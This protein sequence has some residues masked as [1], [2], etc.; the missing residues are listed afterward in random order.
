MFSPYKVGKVSVNP[1]LVLAPMS[2]VTTSAF[3]RLVKELNPGAVGLVMTEFISV[4]ALSRKVQRSIDMMHYDV[5]EHPLAIQ[6]FGYDIERL[7]ESARMAE[8][9]GAD[10]VDIN[11]GCPAP[12]VVKK[13]GG[14]EL[15]RQPDHL[16]KMIAAARKAIS[17]PLTIKIRSGWDEQSKNALE[18]ATMAEQEGVDA[19]A[20]HGRTRAQLYRGEADWDLVADVASKLSIP[21]LGSGDVTSRASADARLR[22]G[23]GGIM[24]GRGAM[25]NPLVFSEVLSGEVPE[26]RMSSERAISILDR[27]VELLLEQFEPRSAV[28]KVKQLASQMCRGMVWRK[29]ILQSRDFETLSDTL[30]SVRDQLEPESLRDIIST[31]EN[32]AA[33]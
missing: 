28:G 33:A 30:Q 5:A 13:G 22:H 16:R 14:C 21:V 27:Y 4:E 12:K 32:N 1:G 9:T 15:M 10:I 29:P 25:K 8:A 23:L 24:I 18:I 7:C 17:V 6:I 31:E 11:C 2:G 19:L 20:I 3:R 26:G